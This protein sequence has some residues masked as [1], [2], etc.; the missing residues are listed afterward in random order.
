[1]FPF[2]KKKQLSWDESLYL[3]A[4]VAQV[5]EN[6]G[7]YGQSVSYLLSSGLFL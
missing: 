5:Q 2:K 7:S 1:M 4:L 3:E 6:S